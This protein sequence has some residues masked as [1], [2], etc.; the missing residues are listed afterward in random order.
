METSQTIAKLSAA[1]AK[2]QGEIRG[3]TKDSTNPHF[4]SKYADLASVRDA[5]QEPLSKA[6]ISYVQ[7][8]EGGPE[9]LTIT[10]LLSCG[11][12]WIKSSFSIKPVKADPQGLGSAAT[13]GRRYALMAAVGVAPEDDD[14]NAASNP[15]NGQ[16]T[17]PAKTEPVKVKPPEGVTKIKADL[18][19]K[20][21][22]IYAELDGPQTVEE[23]D[24]LMGTPQMKAALKEVRD[25]YSQAPDYWADWSC[26]LEDGIADAR[27]NLMKPEGEPASDGYVDW[28]KD[29][30]KRI[31]NA[32]AKVLAAIGDE[33]RDADMYP[34]DK[35][36][37][38]S[39]WADRKRQLSV[40]EAA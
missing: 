1:L 39:V 33:I 27:R 34:E 30:K 16:G 5:I 23:F 2:A 19:Q 32:D 29:F 37:L 40:K 4:R 25:I 31:G 21:R 18:S 3:A 11:D 12:E 7:S 15:K 10:T 35:Q 24:T 22:H 20:L 28:I 36:D 13:Y 9:V 6:G 26:N 14:G 17:G 38:R 8:L